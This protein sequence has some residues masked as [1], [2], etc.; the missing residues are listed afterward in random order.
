MLYGEDPA[1]MQ[2]EA[3]GPGVT[4]DVLHCDTC[5]DP[6]DF[7][8]LSEFVGVPPEREADDKPAPRLP[9]FLLPVYI[10]HG[11]LGRDES[12]RPTVEERERLFKMMGITDPA[13]QE[14]W[15]TLWGEITA[16]Q[17]TEERRRFDAI[18]D[19]QESGGTA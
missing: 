2:C 11:E 12:G 5:G 19:A 7:A 18:S 15:W 8:D 13:E 9:P 14:V 16:A 3:C 4:H 1:A 17:A 6:M 10:A